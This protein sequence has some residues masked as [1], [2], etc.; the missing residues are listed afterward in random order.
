[1]KTIK[2]LGLLALM[3][4][5]VASANS[6]ITFPGESSSVSNAPITFPTSSKAPITLYNGYT[7]KDGIFRSEVNTCHVEVDNPEYE[8]KLVWQGKT[9][10]LLIVG[11]ENPVGCRALFTVPMEVDLTAFLQNMPTHSFAYLE[12]ENRVIISRRD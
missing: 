10:K 9:P 6:V 1:M 7:I 3:A 5:S 4:S 2:L 11:N 8:A 12:V